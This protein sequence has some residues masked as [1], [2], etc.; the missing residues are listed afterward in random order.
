MSHRVGLAQAGMIG[1]LSIGAA[2]ASTEAAAQQGCCEGGLAPGANAWTNGNLTSDQWPPDTAPAGALPPANLP[3]KAP[4]PPDRSWWTH[5]AIELGTRDFINNPTPG[6]SIFGNTITGGYVDL[7]QNSLAKY[8]E[9][10]KIMPGRFA[11]G[12]VAAGSR[13]GIYG[14]D[15]WANNIG[16]GDQSYLL[17]ASKIGEHYFSFGWDQAPHV[18][19]TSAMTPYLGTGR[20]PLIL[21]P[22]LGSNTATDTSFV[23]PFL[24]QTDVAI[25][26]NTASANYR[27]TPTDAWDVRIDYSHMDRTGSQ[28]AGVTGFA[29]A[30]SNVFASPT[31]VGAPVSDTTQNLDVNGEYAG[32]SSWGQRYTF[33][34]AYVGSQYTDNFSSYGVQNPYCTGATAASC[35]NPSLSPFAQI[36]TP[37][38]NQ[39]HG[40]GGTL[41]AELPFK[42]RYVGTLHYTM[43]SQNAAF[44][45]MTANP[46]AA[47]SPFGGGAPWNSSAALPASSLN[48]EINTILSNNT[49]TSQI[50]S[51]LKSK[52]TYRYY[53]FDN[54]TPRIIFPSWVPY[55]STGAPGTRETTI[56][57]LSIG[58][59]RQNAGAALNWRPSEEWNW[60]AEYGYERYNYSQADVDVTNENSAKVSVD[61]KPDNWL[62]ARASGYHSSRTYGTYDY[63]SFV[64]AIQFPTVPGFTP[65]TFGGWFYSPAYRQFMFDGRHRTKAQFLFDVIVVRG[66]TVTPNVKYQNDS[67][68]VDPVTREGV[69]NSRS[70]SWGIDVGFVPSRNLSFTVSYESEYYNQS[71]YNY[72]DVANNSASP[73][74]CTAG[75]NC[76]IVNSDKQHVNTWTAVANIAAIPDKLDFDLRYAISEGVDSQRMF[77]NSPPGG[78]FECQGQFPSNTTLFERFDATATY[79]FDRS[80]LHQMGFAGDVRAKLR[81]T[82]ERNS[83]ANWQN[84]PLAP[85]TNVAGLSDAIW[86]AYNN[87]NYNVQMIAASLISVW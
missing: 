20:N 36:S 46:S 82:W 5:G 28:V 30:G 31:Q 54:E 21:P 48:G 56:S 11:G 87:P 84:D 55:D 17:S 60:N 65:T 53:G 73:G 70:T 75:A 81:Y 29:P 2:L 7:G 39:A 49:L 24:H 69:N 3:V 12:H 33:K 34:V 18:Y 19:S 78:C 45:P 15:F 37:P 71:F 63:P 25:E 14:L 13:D 38:S 8:Y 40:F 22:G 26:R 85:F 79:R 35:P 74:N 66:I 10:S 51:D 58:Y 68:D 83:V 42:S 86:L 32:I 9:Y 16:Y 47:A 41:A 72:T 80:F 64:Q 57:S 4:P 67:Y 50:T 43:M 61:W 62:T 77:T 27:W 23:V 76:L 6:G 52:L 59:A 1:A 44:Q